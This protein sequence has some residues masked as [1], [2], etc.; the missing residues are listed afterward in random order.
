MSAAVAKQPESSQ[1]TFGSSSK[2]SHLYHRS[3]EH[4]DPRDFLNLTQNILTIKGNI[5]R[6]LSLRFLWNGRI[7]GAFLIIN[8]LDCVIVP[9]NELTLGILRISLMIER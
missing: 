6:L 9:A 8:D 2:S 3:A 4:F 1:T 5:R 7:D